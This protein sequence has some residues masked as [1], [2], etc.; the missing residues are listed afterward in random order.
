[1][2]TQR[3]KIVLSS[4]AAIIAL[5]AL[6]LYLFQWNMLR[7]PIA[8]QVSQKLGREFVIKGDLHVHLS[9]QP[10]ITVEDLQLANA[11]W[12]TTPV[13][14]TVRK[15]EFDLPLRPLWH[16]QVELPRV[17]ITEPN[18]LLEQN[19]QGQANWNFDQLTAS[20]PASGSSS[21]SVKLGQLDVV[22]GQIHYLDAEGSDVTAKV[23]TDHGVQ[24]KAAAVN[25]DAK[26]AFR[27]LDFNV[28]AVGGGLLNLRDTTQ[29]YP[30]QVTGS[31]DKTHFSAKGTV[32]NPLQMSGLAINFNLSG[33]SLAQLYPI[34]KLPLPA[35]PPY[36]LAGN[37]QHENQVWKLQGF[38]GKVG[39]SD[40]GG[41]FAVDL[42]RKP[43]F[44]TAN[45]TSRRV[46]LQDFSGFIGARQESGQPAPPKG[47]RILPSNPFNLDKLNIADADVKFRGTQI[48]NA[49]LPLDNIQTHLLLN[50][51]V[52]TLDPLNVGVAGGHVVA[53]LQMDSGATPLKTSVDMTAAHLQL[54]QLVPS[55]GESRQAS[56]GLVGGKARLAMQ[57]NSVAQML[58]SANGNVAV[59][60]DGGKISKLLLRLTNL[61]LA[62]LLPIL[63]T[64]DKP[65]P[66]RCMVADLSAQNGDATIKTFVLDTDK[67]VINGSGNINFRDEKLDM[68]LK[69]DPKDI[70][71]AALR[72]PI[73]I[74]GT[75]KKPSVKPSLPQPVGRTAA[76]VAL[77]FVYPPLVLLP[78]IEVG[79]AKD[80][81]CAQLMQQADT[82]AKKNPEAHP[83]S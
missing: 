69:V 40:V 54:E 37:L 10:T 77:A 48:V 52:L 8:R 55:L 19:A 81:P 68:A 12:S 58:G 14:A 18:V 76:A 56:A 30:L 74:G 28:T 57:G 62:N 43:K 45:L 38:A 71:L 42:A 5:F 65:V 36:R 33:Q 82:N 50:N 73:D 29:P 67:Q 34:L 4:L 13:M 17:V 46:D 20:S 32:T 59:I 60:M 23:A 7:G 41:D 72:G 83:H 47:D 53:Q 22:N 3:K 16:R 27:K 9:M 64:G 66:V 15:L 61:D 35:T 2:A 26:G 25:V 11:S 24:G 39:S 1:M 80:S 70:S 6:A 51:G 75:F 78:L 63:F 79:T 21:P 31:V 44:I 49:S